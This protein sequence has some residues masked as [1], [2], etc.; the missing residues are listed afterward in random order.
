[1]IEPP[2]KNLFEIPPNKKNIAQLHI[3]GY[4]LIIK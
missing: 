3:S 1:M 2:H 4:I